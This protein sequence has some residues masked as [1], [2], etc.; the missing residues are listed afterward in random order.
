MKVVYKAGKLEAVIEG[1]GQKEI[2]A[3]IAKFEEIFA[4]EPCGACGSNETRYVVRDVEGNSYHEKKCTKCGAALS[5][6]AL[7]DGSGLFPKRKN[8][9]GSWD[10][11]SKGWHKWQP[12]D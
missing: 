7:K 5:Y 2:F 8:P 6:G 1:S 10:N 11:Q 12:K 9:D 4:D 3:G